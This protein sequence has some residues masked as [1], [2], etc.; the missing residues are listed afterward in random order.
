[1]KLLFQGNKKK[2]KKD[3]GDKRGVSLI[4]SYVLLIL[5][6]VSLGGLVYTFLQYKTRMPQEIRCPE[7][8]SVW[9]ENYTKNS[10]GI[11]FT[12]KN[13]G[14]F[15]ISGINIVG[16]N[17]SG[18]CNQTTLALLT[19]LSPSN[20]ILYE[21]RCPSIT[22]IKILPYRTDEK[23]KKIICSEALITQNLP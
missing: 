5:L 9:L 18:I 3:K 2:E 15:N 4:V 11:N 23:G 14:L 12:L 1:M 22:Q 19:Q 13:I 8:V 7:G 16:F 20:E 10:D 21:F 17:A 6:S